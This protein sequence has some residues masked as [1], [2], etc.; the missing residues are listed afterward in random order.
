MAVDLTDAEIRRLIEVPKRLPDNY[1]KRL[2]RVRK[3][4][5]HEQSNVEVASPDGQF[6][7]MLRQNTI[8]RF[9]FSAIL[10]YRLPASNRVFRLR[11]YNGRHRHTNKLERE[12]IEGFHIHEATE[13]YQARGPREDAFAW[14]A[15]NYGTLNEA[16]ECLFRDCNVRRPLDTTQGTLPFDR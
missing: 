2:S 4:R 10:G 13:R 8:N 14:V 1:E 11:R 6:V 12:T 15:D 3:S 16:L 5:Q 9:D 7:V